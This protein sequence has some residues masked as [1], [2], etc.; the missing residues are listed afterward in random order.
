MIDYCERVGMGLWAEPINVLTN[1]AFLAA[2]VV[3]WRL[4]R[5]AGPLE[6]TSVALIALMA[7][8][9][10]GSVLF[11]T[12]AT[13]WARVLDELPILAFEALFLW[14]YLRGVGVAGTIPTALAVAGLLIGSLIGRTVPHG[15]EWSLPYVPALLALTG[16]AVYHRR[17][18][19][20]GSLALSGAAGVFALSL[21]FRTIDGA[22]CASVPIGTHFLWHVL[23][24]LVL[25]LAFRALLASLRTQREPAR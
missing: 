14:A 13:P 20:E 21:L 6:A 7:G 23:N 24:A 22:V 10:G 15:V 5:R 3:A 19:R 17:T 4:A 16:L 9:G 12:F 25:Y 1:A 8:V 18:R 11:H 2:A